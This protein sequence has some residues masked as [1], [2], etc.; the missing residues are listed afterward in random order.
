MTSRDS[1]SITIRD[2]LLQDKDAFI[3]LNLDWIQEYFVVEDSDREQL[4]RLEDSILG[5]GGQIIVAELDERVVGTGAIMPAHHQSPDGRRWFEIIKMATQRE[6]RGK[7][8]GR[9]VLEGLVSKARNSKADAIWLE[10]NSEMVTA[11][12][13]YESFGFRQLPTSDWWPTPYARCNSQMV[14]ELDKVSQGT[15][16]F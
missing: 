16:S 14:L 12:H 9:A 11:T 10:T 4:E 5:R 3:E 7:G 6:H 1:A 13:L 8:I 15:P 2:F